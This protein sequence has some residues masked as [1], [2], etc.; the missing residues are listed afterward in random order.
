MIVNQPEIQF[1]PKG[2][3]YE[4]II[5]NNSKYCGK[6]LYIVESKR[7]SVHY[8]LIKDETFFVHSGKL[9]LYFYDD[10]EELEAL[11]KQ[12]G[13]IGIQSHMQ[14]IT[15]KPGDNFYVPPGRVHQFI[16]IEN[17]QLFEFSTHHEDSDSYRVIKGN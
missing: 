11:I 15:L 12:N 9:Y 5:I 3:G 16:A 7:C 6:L 17:T 10:V 13:E 8:H 4:Q 14:H 1:V 2:W